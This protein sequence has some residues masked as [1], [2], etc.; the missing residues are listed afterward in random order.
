MF[1]V[2]QGILHCSGLCMWAINQVY[3][4]SF[5]SQFGRTTWDFDSSMQHISM[6]ELKP[7]DLVFSHIDNNSQ[8]VGIYIGQKDGVQYCIH[9]PEPGQIVRIQ[10]MS[11]LNWD[12]A[13]RYKEHDGN[14]PV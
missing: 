1:G 10:P 9:A 11:E 4:S 14:N 2:Q 12:S 8:H 6:N 7:G 3:G 5:E 13:L